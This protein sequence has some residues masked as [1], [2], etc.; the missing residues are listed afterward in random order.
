M[1]VLPLVS[2]RKQ[3][4]RKEEKGRDVKEEVREGGRRKGGRKDERKDQNLLHMQMSLIF[5][6]TDH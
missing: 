6:L 3:N 4:G 5:I 1:P 2:K